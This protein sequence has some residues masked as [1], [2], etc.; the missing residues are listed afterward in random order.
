MFLSIS[1]LSRIL[2]A[3]FFSVSLPNGM[4]FNFPPLL[5]TLMGRGLAPHTGVLT[6]NALLGDKPFIRSLPHLCFGII[7]QIITATAVFWIL[8]TFLPQLGVL[9]G[10]LETV[11]TILPSLPSRSDD[12]LTAL[13]LTDFVTEFLAS[14]CEWWYAMMMDDQRSG[15]GGD[16][17][18]KKSS[19]LI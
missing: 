11:A 13:L 14:A 1:L 12:E 5:R 16:V 3:I 19:W 6:V 2:L 4:T 7:A 18:E 15:R 8:L 17:T 9:E 10:K